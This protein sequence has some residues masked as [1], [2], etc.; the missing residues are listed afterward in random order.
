[1]G[2]WL[3]VR[4]TRDAEGAGTTISASLSKDGGL[5]WQDHELATLD[6]NIGSP[7]IDVGKDQRWIITFATTVDFDGTSGT[8]FDIVAMISD[9][10]GV[11]KQL[12]CFS[13]ASVSEQGTAWRNH[14]MFPPTLTGDLLL[15]LTVA[16]LLTATKGFRGKY[17]RS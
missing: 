15:L 4:G 3:A 8:D 9:R 13:L 16:S 5:T 6:G 10:L 1:M 11:P 17:V 2:N 14:A 12:S 7:R